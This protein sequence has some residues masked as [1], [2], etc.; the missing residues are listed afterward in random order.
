MV[1]EA[2]QGTLIV[3]SFGICLGRDTT[4]RVLA[5]IEQADKVFVAGDAYC[6]SYVLAKRPDATDLTHLYAEGKFRG[7]TYQEMQQHMVD[8]VT[9]GN[10]VCA[11]F[12]GHAAV[13]ADAPRAAIKQLRALGYQAEM[14]PGISA[15]ACLYADLLIDPG[16]AG[17]QSYEATQFLLTQ[18]AF[19]PHVLLLLWQISLAGELTGKV[20]SSTAERVQVLVDKLL[21]Y[22]PPDHE[23]ILYEAAVLA[24]ESPRIEYVALADLAHAELTQ[25]TTLAVPPYQPSQ[26]PFDKEALAALGIPSD[27]VPHLKYT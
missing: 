24:I 8:A 27:A 9:A 20:F 7:Q 26:P 15:E 14:L 21:R 10:R 16:A 22:Y 3:A 23:V 17:V 4:Q 13:F 1:T 6:R 12:Y 11:V 2:Q 18:R 19:D 25:I 5:E